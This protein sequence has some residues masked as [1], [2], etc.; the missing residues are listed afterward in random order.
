V[1]PFAANDFCI[2]ANNCWGAEIYKRYNLPFNTPIIG[3]YFYPEDYLNFISNLEENLTTEITFIKESKNI[4]DQV[5]PI[6]IINDIEV[7]FLHYDSEQE[8]YEKWTKRCKR[9]PKNPSKLFFKFDDRD[10]ATAEHIHRFHQMTL[11]N[12]ICF[13]KDSFPA[14]SD[15]FQ[16][17]MAKKDSSVM[18]GYD[19][20]YVADKYF[21]LEIWLSS[22]GISSTGLH[23][24]RLMLRIIKTK[25]GIA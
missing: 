10:G 1:K 14:Y 16:I 23:R 12:K 11:R 13:T 15:V 8:A 7:H 6:G 24:L 20:F 19:Q 5:H 2:I 4:K 17:P 21:S 3:L 9:V 25:L 18:D 22:N